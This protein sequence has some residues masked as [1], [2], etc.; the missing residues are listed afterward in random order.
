[1]QRGWAEHRTPFRRSTPVI[2]LYPVGRGLER[3][4]YIVARRLAASRSGA[5]GRATEPG[6]S[7]RKI[8]HPCRALGREGA[9]G[10]RKPRL[11]QLASQ[12]SDSAQRKR[13]LVARGIDAEA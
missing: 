3:V 12:E 5:E 13:N 4:S 8:R 6:G 1:M 7:A 11:R 2:G 10:D 9:R